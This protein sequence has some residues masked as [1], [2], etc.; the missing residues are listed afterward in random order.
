M[1]T[2]TIDQL[3]LEL[4]Q[5]TKAK[6][7]Q[8]RMLENKLWECF[9]ILNNTD[10]ADIHAQYIY[11]FLADIGS[12]HKEMKVSDIPSFRLLPKWPPPNPEK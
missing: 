12:S 5:V 6:T 3:F 7:R 1:E 4:S 9:H 11:S 2:G 8:E 10:G